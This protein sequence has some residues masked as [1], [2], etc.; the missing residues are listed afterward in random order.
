MAR[1]RDESS[2]TKPRRRRMRNALL[3]LLA[4]LGLGAFVFTRPAV[5]SRLILPAANRAIGGEVTAARIGLDGLDALVIDDLRIRAR[6]WSGEAGE[7][8]Y[9]DTMRVEFSLWSLLFGDIEVFAVSVGRL[10]L[11]LAEREDTPGSFSL[12]ALEPEPSRRATDKRQRPARITIE[13]LLVENGVV[14]NGAYERLGELRF[15]GS[16]APIAESPAAFSFK[17]EGKPDEQGHLPVGEISGSFDGDSRAVDVSVKELDL[18]GEQLAVAPLAVRAWTTRLGLKGSIPSARFSYSP[19]TA[20]SAE[21]DIRGVAMDLPID[22]LGGPSLAESWSGLVNG[23]LVPVRAAPR[24]TLREG[25]LRLGNDAVALVGLK[26][27]LGA[28]GA[29]VISLP[30][31]CDL[32]LEIPRAELPP[33][34]WDRREEWI[35]QAARTAGFS[36]TAAIRDFRSPEPKQGE[37][38]MLQLPRVVAKVIADFRITAWTLNLETRL[39]RAAPGKDGAPAPLRT[40][41]SLR[42][43]QGSGAYEEFPYRLDDVNGV[44]NF[45]NDDVIVERI[46]GRGGDGALVTIEGKLV[47]IATGA[48]IN[49]SIRC[50]DAPID[51]RLFDAFDEGP[52]EA[53]GL[54]FDERSATS[55]ANAGLLPDAAALVDQRQSLARLGPDAAASAEATR[56]Q[57]SLDAGPF[58]LGGRAGFDIHVYSPAGF[59]TPVIVTGDVKVRDAGLVFGRFPYPLRIQSGSIAILDEAIVIGGG[60]LHAVTPAGGAFVV[61][62]SVQIPRDGKGGRDLHPLIEISADDDAV[63]PA[64][65]AAIPFAGDEQAPGWPGKDLAPAGELLRALGLSGSLDLNGFV[66][67]RPDGTES[68]SVKI[69]FDRGRAAPD[70]EGRTWLSKQGLPWPEGFELENCSAKLDISPERVSFDDC[71]GTRGDG[72]IEANGYADLNGPGRRVELKLDDLP[73]ERAFEGYLG[74]TPAESKSRFERLRPSGI[75]DGSVTRTVDGSQ[76]V[77]RGS[78]VPVWLE[79]T[80]DGVRVRADHL[81]GQI[82][83]DGDTVRA[84]SLEL[85]LSSGAASDGLLR[86]SG[87]LST[88]TLDAQWSGGRVESPVLREILAARGAGLVSLLKSR[89][90]R[91]VFDAR[92]SAAGG[93]K[94]EVAPKSLSVGAEKERVSFAFDTTSHIT[95]DPKSMQFDLRGTLG[96]GAQGSITLGGEVDLGVDSRLSARLS[97]D[98]AA[99]TPALREVLPPPLDLSARSIDL[100]TTGRFLLDLT[101]IDLRWPSAGSASEPDLYG[102]RGEAR[103]DGAAFDAGVRFTEMQA[104]LPI[105]FRYQPDAAQPINFETTL[106]STGS[107]AMGRALGKSSARIVSTPDGRGLTIA[108]AGDIAGGRFD[109]RS[110]LDFERDRYSV[111]ARIAEAAFDPLRDPSAPVTARG[112]GKV[113]ARLEVEGQTGGT[114]AAAAA[115]TGT[116]DVALRDARLASTPIAMRILQLTQ[117]MLPLNSSLDETEAHMTIKGSTADI[118]SVRLSSGTIHL[119]GT[120]TM[121]IPSLAVAMRLSAKGTVPVLSDL[122]GGVTGA[123]F[124]IDVKGTLDEPQVSIAPLPG[125]TN[126]PTVTVPLPEPAPA[127]AAPIPA[128]SPANGGAA[129]AKVAPEDRSRR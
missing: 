64:L 101:D 8:A 7:V 103:L 66:T 12:L 52:R 33:F 81:A 22:A 84:D 76:A 122:I 114:P 24:L 92:Y 23:A 58:R 46:T 56:L 10:N 6:G 54:L 63:N 18:D 68:F 79:V 42:L 47:D 45:E 41:G 59:G 88:E 55:L 1:P 5:L 113:T 50:E 94:L 21:L 124:A 96:D 3:A 34:D 110:D 104:S 39:E 85:R 4:V 71:K 19:D 43:A 119:S 72:A 75:L 20:P 82:E 32:T 25:T 109:V 127:P 116:L 61:A 67:T 98:A 129:A 40:S 89:D 29:G 125:M 70:A 117:L 49:L 108:A 121:D 14:A 87:Q 48:E 44:V 36:M 99:L 120:G 30:F 60:G 27:D 102:L 115:R 16:L 107:K 11:R 28:E 73:I 93:E 123:I 13:E 26:G 69:D 97:L 31:D 118:T 15:R 105:S 111:L 53:I 2:E 106:A 95:A 17:L 126:E 86:L 37:P 57:R 65:L 9:A 112:G 78:L 62:G 74:D 128:V 90:A 100:T 51:Q 77:T 35:E 38:D 91:G 80:M 83:V